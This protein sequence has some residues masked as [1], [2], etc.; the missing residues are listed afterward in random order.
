ME[1]N[2]K[3]LIIV[4]CLLMGVQQSYAEELRVIIAQP[5]GNASD[6]A[7]RKLFSIYDRITN[8]KTIIE[9]RAGGAMTLGPAY[10]MKS[11]PDGKT[12]L[13]ATAAHLSS[14]FTLKN[15]PYDLMKDFI[16]VT[17]TLKNTFLMGVKKGRFKNEE[18]F[19]KTAKRSPM[20]Y[21]SL[22]YGSTSHIAGL[23]YISNRGL[24]GIV[25]SYKGSVDA[26][27]DL[28]GDRLDFCFVPELL[29]FG[30]D[31]DVYSSIPFEAWHGIFLPNNT[32][33][34]IVNKIK[35]NINKAKQTSEFVEWVKLTKSI[36]FHD[37]FKEYL[38]KDYD[39]YKILI[40]S[41]DLKP[42]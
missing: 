16:P 38:K 13:Y 15:V 34:T 35:E 28:L 36:S 12:L 27:T 21:C 24:D 31:I 41:I 37:D 6:I 30:K 14:M 42:Q 11:E 22:S 9:N 20:T 4:L 32:P 29:F 33:S 7:A 19:I 2:M 26:M 40:D 5:A 23:N 10:V 25:V 1:K 17:G 39:K 18:D 3:I 8:T